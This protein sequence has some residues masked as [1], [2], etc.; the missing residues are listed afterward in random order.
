M[1]GLLSTYPEVDNSKLAYIADSSISAQHFDE[2]FFEQ[3]L[4]Q[5]IVIQH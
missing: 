2:H 5:T 3:I 1:E 4:T